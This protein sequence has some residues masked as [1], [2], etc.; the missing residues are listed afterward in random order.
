[1]E[2]KKK[3]NR[4]KVVGQNKSK[5]AGKGMAEGKEKIMCR[6]DQKKA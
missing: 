6:E 4:A 1:L 5:T 3:L 2:R